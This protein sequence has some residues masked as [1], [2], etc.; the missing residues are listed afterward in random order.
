MSGDNLD[1]DPERLAG[2][3]AQSSKMA[4]VAVVAAGPEL[5]MPPAT[6]ASPLDAV[7]VA[8]AKE[9][10]GAVTAAEAADNAAVRKQAAMLAESPSVIVQQDQS[11]ADDMVVAG[12][13]MKTIKYSTLHAAPST[14]DGLRSV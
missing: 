6:V 8:L 12:E 5:V 7:L 9:I 3:A 2:Y 4:T 14:P 13:G 1:I 10:R 11:G